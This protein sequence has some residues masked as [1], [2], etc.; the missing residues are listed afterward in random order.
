[1]LRSII[2]TIVPS[3]TLLML[4]QMWLLPENLLRWI[5]V[6]VTVD[7]TC[8]VSLWLSRRGLVRPGSQLLLA[9]AWVM[10]SALS[11]TAGGIRSHGVTFYPLLVLGAGL[12]LGVRTGIVT[13]VVCSLSGLGFVFAE[14][15]GFLPVDLVNY[16]APSLWIMN[17]LIMAI[18][19]GI[20][21]LAVRTVENALRKAESELTERRRA[22]AAW[23]DS[24]Q[25]YRAIVDSV[26]DAIFLHDIETGAVLDVNQRACEMMGYT[27]EELRR[28]SIGEFGTNEPPFNAEEA[29]RRFQLAA[30][31]QPQLFDWH[32]RRKDGRPFWAEVDLRHAT[33]GGKRCVIATTHDISKRKR[34]EEALRESEERYR[35]AAEQTGKLVYDYDVP[36]GVIRWHGAITRVTGWSAAEFPATTIE[37]WEELIHPEDRA[38]AL[39]E[40]EASMKEQRSYEVEYRFRRKDGSYAFLEDQGVYLCDRHLHPV[41]MLGSMGDITARKQAEEALRRSEEKF[42]AI[43][44]DQTEMIVRWKPD[45]TRTFVNAAYCRAFGGKPEDFVGSSFYPLIVEEDREKVRRK[46][47]AMT[48]QNPVVF[49]IHR[50]ILPSGQIRWQEWSD[51]GVFDEQGTLLELQSVGRDVTDRKRAEDR[52]RRSREQL[53]ALTSRLQ[54]LREEE[55]ARISREIHDQL[56]QFLTALKLD[57]HSIKRAVGG[58]TRAA[59]ADSLERKVD[60]AIDLANQTIT[61]VQKIAAELRP[62]V[63]DRLGLAAAIEG[64][65]QAF[66]ARTGI[67]CE[68]VLPMNPVEVL[69]DHATAAFRILQESLTNVARH[70]KA[71]HVEVRLEAEGGE[72]LLEVVDDGTGIRESDLANPRS[73]GLLGMQERAAILGGTVTFA[74]NPGKGTTVTIRLPLTRSAGTKP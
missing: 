25:R 60:S 7:S 35:I 42:R 23:R 74:G 43:V 48:P 39:R 44:D 64:E 71:S 3:V 46:L 67:P 17:T 8:L 10:I 65:A 27:L 49:D 41:R 32:G 34:A 61:S 37:A 20:Q 24:E 73:L 50:S 19:L 12:L 56:G 69:P 14:W 11:W 31:G 22:E 28:L 15:K 47:D 18:A 66:Q 55:R 57:L 40:L 1:M 2:W 29:R 72:L 53:R 45:G 70:A 26:N 54:T 5:T 30:A 13:A 33:L 51:R 21:F 62:V 4:V 36:T 16:R 6:I 63:L 59:R 9:M 38:E 58:P 68:C 52:Q